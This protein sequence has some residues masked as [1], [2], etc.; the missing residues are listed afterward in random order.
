M[1]SDEAWTLF[2]R[3]CTGLDM[4]ILAARVPCSSVVT[5]SITDQT[6]AFSMLLARGL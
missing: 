3:G 5:I 6:N 2:D 1:S 4:L